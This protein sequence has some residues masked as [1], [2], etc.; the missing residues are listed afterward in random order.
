MRK[1]FIFSDGSE[2][3]FVVLGVSRDPSILVFHGENPSATQL[4]EVGVTLLGRVVL[5][6]GFDKI[7]ALAFSPQRKRDEDRFCGW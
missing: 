5:H 4:D 6:V 3:G 7:R 2:I 1:K